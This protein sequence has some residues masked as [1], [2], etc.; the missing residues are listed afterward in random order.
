MHRVGLIVVA[1]AAGLMSA[2]AADARADDV[3]LDA[4]G[5]RAV[6]ERDSFR[7]TVTTRAPSTSSVLAS[8]PFDCPSLTK[9]STRFSKVRRDSQPSNCPTTTNCGSGL[10]SSLFSTPSSAMA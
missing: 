6:V 5:A 3:V 7:L 9:R 2:A 4:G 8:T 10:P 1:V